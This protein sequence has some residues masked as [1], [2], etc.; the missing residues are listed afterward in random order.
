MSAAQGI[1]KRLAE[2]I[3]IIMDSGINMYDATAVQV[4]ARRRGYYDL[5]LFVTGQRREY[6]NF[7]LS[8]G[9]RSNLT[10]DDRGGNLIPIIPVF[11]P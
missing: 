2:R 5:V 9:Y 7:Y 4:E 6:L 10:S 11:L 3:L 1:S 8:P